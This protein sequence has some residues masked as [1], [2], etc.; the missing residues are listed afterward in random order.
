MD[1][2]R[3]GTKQI[4]S[5]EINMKDFLFKYGDRAALIK[6]GLDLEDQLE[7]AKRDLQEVEARLINL[8]KDLTAQLAHKIKQVSNQPTKLEL[9]RDE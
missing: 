4:D 3:G 6:Y 2:N 5:K 1:S 9:V 7:L 8:Q